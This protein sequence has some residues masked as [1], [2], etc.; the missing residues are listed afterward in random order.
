MG[1]DDAC[2]RAY[3]PD[4]RARIASRR[5]AFIEDLLQRDPNNALALA[6]LAYNWH[7]GGFFG[8]RGAASRCYGADG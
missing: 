8:D 2:A 4:L 5:S 6:E 3:P 1:A 7:M